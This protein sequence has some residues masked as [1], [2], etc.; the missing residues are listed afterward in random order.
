MT[1]IVQAFASQIFVTMTGRIGQAVVLD[2]R[3]RLFAHMLRLSVSFPRAI[4][5]AG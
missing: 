2:L 5:R 1:V 3:R 4:R